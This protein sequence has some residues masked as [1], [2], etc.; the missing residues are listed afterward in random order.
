M[1]TGVMAAEIQLCHPGI[2]YFSKY[3]QIE[4][5]YFKCMH[6]SRCFY[7]KR[8][9]VLSGYTLFLFGQ[10]MCSLGIEP[11][12]FALLTQCSTT[13]P[14]RNTE[15]V[16]IFHNIRVLY[17][18]FDQINAALVSLRDFFQKHLKILPIPSFAIILCKLDQISY[19]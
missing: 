13:E 4:K 8:L 11:T 12:T 1:K 9:T 19:F 7:P 17:S 2:H 5:S 6:F 10:Y 18:I 14:H 15:N 3:F 16:I